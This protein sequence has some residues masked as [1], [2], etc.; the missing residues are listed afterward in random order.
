MDFFRRIL[1]SNFLIKLRSWEYWPFGIIQAPLF[2]YFP[3]LSLKAGSLFFFSASNPGIVMGGMFGE[4]KFD[5]LGLVPEGIKPKTIRI[6]FPATPEDVLAEIRSNDLLFPL[7]FKP[8]LGERGWMVKRIKNKNDIADYLKQIKI[9]FLIQD[10]VNL[11][12]EFG[13]FYIRHPNQPQG[14]VTSIVL[15]EMLTITGNGKKTVAELILEND[16]A[17]LQWETLKITYAPVL[18]KVL[19]SDEGLELVSIGNH[20]LGTKFLNGNH[21]ITDKL[22]ASFDAISKQIPGF[23]FGRFDLRAATFEDLENGVVQVVELNGCGAE[24]AH[25]YDPKFSLARAMVVLFRHWRDIYEISIEN[26]RRGVSYISF[27]EGKNIF[28]KF[29]ALTS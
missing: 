12:L 28:K 3:W 21:L 9:D 10:F 8:D 19:A 29:R 6:K 17:K 23:Y 11:P 5:V 14:R 24:P 1:R 4:S 20:C 7:I 2:L 27:Q 22:S 18:N 15:K 26:H 13:V 25:I 16:R